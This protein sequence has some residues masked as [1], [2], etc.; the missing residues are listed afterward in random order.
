MRRPSAKAKKAFN[1]FYDGEKNPHHSEIVEY[2]EEGKFMIEIGKGRSAM[3]GEEFYGITVLEEL[4]D[5]GMFARRNELYEAGLES[6]K[7]CLVYI[8]EEIATL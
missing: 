3:T 1:E 7:E 2:M 4:E 8:G 6:Y 5:P